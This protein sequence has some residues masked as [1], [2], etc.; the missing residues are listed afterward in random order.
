MTKHS[1]PGLETGNSTSSPMR[2]SG[3]MSGLSSS[4]RGKGSGGR[5]GGVS[6]GGGGSW[7]TDERDVATAN[8]HR[9]IPGSFFVV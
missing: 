4:G 2:G 3:S 9:L 5:M 7:W 6:G 8:S 1:L